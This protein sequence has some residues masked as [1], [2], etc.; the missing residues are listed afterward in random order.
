[1]SLL[2]RENNFTNFASFA[3]CW[4]H[5]QRGAAM[6]VGAGSEAGSARKVTHPAGTQTRLP[7]RK[8]S[9]SQ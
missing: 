8:V 3:S 7:A 2:R 1:M 9:Q 6:N 5:L 4:L